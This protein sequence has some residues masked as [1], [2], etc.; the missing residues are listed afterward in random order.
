MNNGEPV[1]PTIIKNANINGGK[2][3][4]NTSTRPMKQNPNGKERHNPFATVM[5]QRSRR[6][7]SDLTNT[8][9]NERRQSRAHTINIKL[10]GDN[11]KGIYN[12]NNTNNNTNNNNNNGN[13]RMEFNQKPHK[14]LFGSTKPAKTTKREILKQDNNND[15]NNNNDNWDMFTFGQSKQENINRNEDGNEFQVFGFNKNANKNKN[16]NDNNR[17]NIKQDKQSN[18]QCM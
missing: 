11:N 2:H 10:F 4:V 1:D 9:L 5:K 13:N 14:L 16:V 15:D 6:F 7:G 8:K 12:N 17:N 18:N 3:F